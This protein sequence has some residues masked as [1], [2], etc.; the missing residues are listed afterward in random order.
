MKDLFELACG[1]VTGKDHRREGRNNHD[2]F[3]FQF[4]DEY[5]VA[6]VTDGCG[7]SKHSE[8]GAKIGA[9]LIVKAAASSITRFGTDDSY[10]ERVRQ[11][12]L[13][14]LRVL[15]LQMGDSLSEVVTDFLLF[16]T[17]GAVITRRI[18]TFF[19]IGDGFIFVNGSMMELGPFPG[20]E[21]PYLGYD[22]TGSS[23]ADAAPELLKF[24][25]NLTLPT[26]EV[27]SFLIGTDGLSH[28][29][30]AAEE[31]IPGKSE[32]VGLISQFWED[33]RYYSNPDNVR[34]R[35]TLINREAITPDWDARILGRQGGHLPDDTTLIVGKRKEE[36]N[37]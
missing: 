18:A 17:V 34:R 22:L 2:G 19:S 28:L 4:G 37:Q 16:A 32:S 25:L 14:Q 30:H 12:I 35:L 10:W 27:S 24:K 11:D 26:S 1:T 13:A 31:C 9:R 6:V 8:V 15:A 23:L 3:H 33:A 21:P 29:I 5:L 7:S 36:E 20:N